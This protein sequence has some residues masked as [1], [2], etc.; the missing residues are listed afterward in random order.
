MQLYISFKWN[1]DLEKMLKKPLTHNARSCIRIGENKPHLDVV[2][3][4]HRPLNPRESQDFWISVN[5]QTRR[6]AVGSGTN[7][8]L[9]TA[10]LKLAP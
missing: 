6:I 8:N 4:Q 3:V 2:S 7:P 10:V 9:L 5:E 1:R